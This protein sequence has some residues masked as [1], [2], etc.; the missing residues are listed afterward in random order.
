M[1]EHQLQTPDGLIGQ[2]AANEI[3]N[4]IGAMVRSVAQERAVAVSRMGTTI[5]DI[6]REELRPVLK[7]W[8]D[9]HLPSLVERIVRAEIE[10]VIDR[11]QL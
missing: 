4:T 9:T 2:H 10:R 3:S 11:S 8:L 7:A 6:V 5:E 1:D